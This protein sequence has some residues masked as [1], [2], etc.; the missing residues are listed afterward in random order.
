MHKY[1]II[2]LSIVLVFACRKKT[3][4][5]ITPPII[6]IVED[7][8]IRGADLSFLPE[9]EQT[10]TQFY[11]IDS[12]GGNVLSIMQSAGCNTVRI[13][14]W[15]NPG[16]THSSFDEVSELAKRVKQNKMK[17][18]LDFHYS[19]TWAD[20]GHQA[21][22]GAWNGL[23][24]AVL[25]DSVYTYTKRVM[26]AIQPEY[27]QIGNEI[28]G[29]LLWNIGSINNQSNF[30]DLLKAGSKACRDALPAS[31]IIIH[32]A[33]L[34]NSEWFYTLLQTN[35]L[36]YDIMGLS[37]YPIWHGRNLDTLEQSLKRLTSL[38]GKK[39]VI[40][41]TS[42]PFTLGWNDYT[43]NII[44][45]TSQIVS[46]YEPT[47]VGQLNFLKK[48]RSILEQNKLGMGF[49]YWG[50][51]WVAFK[52]PVS[53]TGSSWENQAVFNFNRRALPVMQAFKR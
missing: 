26:S 24:V 2:L 19:D 48:I 43:N 49:C 41:E 46:N 5:P 47:S 30:I 4:P 32:F 53:T 7:T 51:E 23:S 17:V 22:P 25:L 39:V 27:V 40:A 45:D 38:T 20:P 44:G 14:L 52:G 11:N 15:V 29:G 18:W 42:Y 31:K 21:L 16:N 6:T 9:I 34:N 37:Y 35:K 1:L 8:F 3:I 12:V 10:G 36:D 13:R 33:G 28:N 50:C